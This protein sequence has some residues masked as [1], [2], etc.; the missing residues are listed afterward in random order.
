MADYRAEVHAGGSVYPCRA[1]LRCWKERA[2]AVSSAGRESIA[3]L[4]DW[5]GVIYLEGDK[6]AAIEAAAWAIYEDEE[7]QLRVDN[8]EGPFL[9]DG[10][11]NAG[12]LRI[13]GSG[14]L[15]SSS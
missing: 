3:G 7:R 1:E 4:P 10:D 13:Q 6:Q 8:L 14:G 9:V 12:V 2:E 5:D 11:F 15:K